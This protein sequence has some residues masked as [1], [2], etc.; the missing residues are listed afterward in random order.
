MFDIFYIMHIFWLFLLLRGC[1]WKVI[2]K[3][4]ACHMPK[5]AKYDAHVVIV[6]TITSLC[7]MF[8]L[9]CIIQ[10]DWIMQLWQHYDI[11]MMS[12]FEKKN[13]SNAV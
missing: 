4:A 12:E 11:N 8:V 1:L 3:T 10:L 6:C 13:V 5:Q 2:V 9:C 7:K